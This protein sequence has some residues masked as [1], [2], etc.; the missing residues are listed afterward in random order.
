MSW[1]HIVFVAGIAAASSVAVAA[2]RLPTV[3]PSNYTDEQRKAAEEFQ[4]TYKA[5]VSGAYEPLI[6]SPQVLL[7]ARAMATYLHYNSA[8]GTAMTE[9]AIMIIAREWTQDYGWN[10]HYP[11]AV[12]AGVKP[13]VLQAVLEGRRPTGMTADEEIVYDFS[14]EL[15]KNKSVSDATF[16]RAEK[17]FGKKG[18]VDLTAIN[19]YYTL[20]AMQLNVARYRISSDWK[21][22]PRFPE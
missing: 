10:G 7:N 5:P 21:K 15:L 9:L 14:T 20:L 8:I 6:Y 1:N 16:A 17:R 19:G 18:V 11:L 2:D 4:A 3:S 22:L 12:A 13:E